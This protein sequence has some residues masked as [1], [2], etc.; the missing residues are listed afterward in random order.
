MKIQVGQV[1]YK[2]RDDYRVVYGTTDA[3]KIYYF[4]DDT[5]LKNGNR[6]AS[7]ELVEAIDIYTPV[8]LC[9]LALVY[10]ACVW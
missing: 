4:L 5:A 8:S 2:G 10:H 6:I 1:K 9:S 7:T 3:G